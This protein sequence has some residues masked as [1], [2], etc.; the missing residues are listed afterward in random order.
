MPAPS[1]RVRP[2]H[3]R[4]FNDGYYIKAR[5]KSP[6][7]HHIVEWLADHAQAKLFVEQLNTDVQ[8][9]SECIRDAK[10]ADF[11]L[12]KSKR[13]PRQKREKVEAP[14]ELFDLNGNPLEE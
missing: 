6:Y 2:Y 7:S 4:A 10:G 8:F 12:E 1:M 3:W 14:D 9:R 5:R 11:Y 13:A